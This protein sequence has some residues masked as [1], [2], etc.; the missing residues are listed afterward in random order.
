MAAP[1]V[2]AGAPDTVR[3]LSESGDFYR[4]APA[5][6]R[7]ANRLLKSVASEGRLSATGAQKSQFTGG[8]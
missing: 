4:A 1:A 8:K 3:K 6:T 7:N 2:E 5:A